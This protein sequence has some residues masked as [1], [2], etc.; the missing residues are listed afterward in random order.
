MSEVYF[1]TGTDTGIGKTTIAVKLLKK[2]AKQGFST[3]GIKPIASG[4]DMIDG[5]LVNDDA[6]QLQS[7]STVKLPYE[8]I[9]P[10]AFKEPIAPHIAASLVNEM[11][12]VERLIDKTQEALSCDAD[13]KI[14]EGAGGW[15]VPLNNN[16]LISDY[17]K[18][19]NAKVILV[20]GMRLGCINHAIQ[21]YRSI[22]A[23]GVE[24][25]G[26]VANCIDADMPY[27]R[28]N[29]EAIDG[30]IFASKMFECWGN[31]KHFMSKSQGKWGKALLD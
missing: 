12:T 13:I 15:S 4:C 18:A 31:F 19:I 30:Y 8:K 27:Q 17:A 3:I 5:Q 6:L 22:C 16:E 7:A 24:L 9:N 29:I 14:V 28:D 21:T 20:V 23:D 11:V 25:A 26:W 10:F 1:I 2:Y